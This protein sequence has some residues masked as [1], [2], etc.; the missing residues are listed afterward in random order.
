MNCLWSEAAPHRA[1]LTPRMSAA[2][3]VSAAL[4]LALVASLQ[5][6][7]GARWGGVESA[8]ARPIRATLLGAPAPQP[9]VEPVMEP[10]AAV[11]AP[12]ESAPPPPPAPAAQPSAPIQAEAPAEPPRALLPESKYYRTRELD[13]PP[14]IMTRV[15]PQYPEAAARR[16]LSGKVVLRLFL[17]ESGQVERAEVVKADPPGYFEGAAERAFLAARFSPGMKDGRPVKVQM[18]LEVA[19]DSPSA[20]DTLRR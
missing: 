20:P 18:V 16:L 3:A 7:F 5:A 10:R 13:V 17:A 8:P 19:F 4:H 9:A 11:P 15:E 14:G 2:L 6:P 1:A 12:A